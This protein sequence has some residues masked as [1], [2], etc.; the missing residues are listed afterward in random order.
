MRDI[1]RDRR[2]HIQRR[3]FLPSAATAGARLS[4]TRQLRGWGGSTRIEI[5]LSGNLIQYVFI[6]EHPRCGSCFL[7]AIHVTLATPPTSTRHEPV[8]AHAQAGLTRGIRRWDLV[9]LVLN[10][11]IG[12]GIF[13]LPSRA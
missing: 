6:R 3:E 7:S 9:A 2:A 8:A 12:A 10:C 1:V 11:V 4:L 5:V 13:G